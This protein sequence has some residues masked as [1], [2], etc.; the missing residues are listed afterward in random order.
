MSDDYQKNNGETD[1][2][3]FLNMLDD[4]TKTARISSALSYLRGDGVER[5]IEKGLAMVREAEETGYQCPEQEARLFAS[6]AAQEALQAWSAENIQKAVK[7]WGL[8][9]H[10]G[11]AESAFN[12]ANIYLSRGS[13][14]S[15]NIKRAFELL[16]FAAEGGMERACLK[17]AD[18]LYDGDIIPADYRRAEQL[19]LKIAGNYASELHDQALY[20][21]G[22]LYTHKLKDY[23]EAFFVWTALADNGNSEAQFA[24]GSFYYDGLGVERDMGQAKYWWGLAAKQGHQQAINNLAVLHSEGL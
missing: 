8:A 4:L 15:V 13:G 17:L 11:D 19:Y 12:L 5:D 24:L 3:E 23:E 18:L 22:L 10:W 14:S 1:W 21:L 9:A 16:D 20:H 7:Y 6:F 2:T